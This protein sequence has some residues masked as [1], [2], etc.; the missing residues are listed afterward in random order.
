[1][2]FDVSE[3]DRLLMTTRSVRR[4]LDRRRPVP[5]ELIREALQVAIQAPTSGGNQDWRWLVVTDPATRAE[6]GRVYRRAS[7]AIARPATGA[8]SAHERA[9]EVFTHHLGE[10]PVLVLAC[11][12]RR[13]WHGRSPHRALV[14]A[15][16]YGSIYPAAWSLQLA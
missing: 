7:E 16:V 6:I 10:V 12:Q 1:M 13:G 14:D 3:S 8:A 2:G 11:Y 4:R 15:S 5:P 9:A